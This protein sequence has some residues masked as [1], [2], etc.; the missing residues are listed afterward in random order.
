MS[1]TALTPSARLPGLLKQVFGYD[2]FR[3]LQREIMEASLARVDAVAIL[4]TGAGKSLCY[5]LPALVRDGLTVVV[6]PLIALMKDQVD[7]LHAAGVEA[8]ALNSSLDDREA[9]KRLQALDAGRI[10]LLFVAPE[11]LVLPDF[12][13]S[14]Q[15]WRVDALAVDE[16]HCISEWG[17][18]FRPEYRRLVSV[19]EVLPGVPVLALTATATPR[20]R[21]DIVTQL[22]LVDPCV[23]VA[24]FNRPNLTYRVKAKEKASAQVVEFVRA[25]STSEA[26]SM[27]DAGIVYCQSRKGTESMAAAL[28][29]KG[30]AAAP[31]HAGLDA[32][33]RARHQ[34]AF[35]RDELR[36]MCATVAFGMGINKPNVRFVIHADL[37]KNIEGY[38]QETGRA[39][40]DGL[41][42]ECLLLYSRGDVAKYIGFLA[43][44]DDLDA[45]RVARAQLDKMAAFADSARCRRVELLGYFGETWR[46]DRCDACDNCI[47]PRE[48]YDATID[49]Q[50]FL[51][52]VWRIAQKDGFGVGLQHVAD[53][54]AGADTE[55]IRRW[56]HHTLSTY[57]IGKDRPRAAWLSLG[58]Q[59]L[60]SGHLLQSAGQFPTLE[61]SELG[62]EALRSRNAILLVKS[63]VT[64]DDSDLIA[65]SKSDGKSRGKRALKAGAIECDEALFDQLRA[66]RK[67]L[68]DARGVPPYVVFSD[69]TLRH[70]A[71]SYPATRDEFLSVPGIGERKY[72]D[73]GSAF[74]DAIAQWLESHARA[75]FATDDAKSARLDA[76]A[77]AKSTSLR[78]AKEPDALNETTMQTVTLFRAG[79]S[80]DEIARVRALA[81][82]TIEGHL[83]AAIES[84]ESF[85][86]ED[87]MSAETAREIDD[88]FASDSSGGLRVIFDKLEGRVSYG[89]LR[90]SLALEQ[91][92]RNAAS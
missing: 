47:D 80:I 3:P 45:R 67:S 28:V 19:R 27:G 4:P 30:V 22:R 21:A 1:T 44:M 46:D 84:G 66:V 39:G 26:D 56:S 25:R 18:D 72:A 92:A 17:H 34:D 42:A 50:K 54:L 51:S 8:T 2:A 91:S 7:Q 88:A 63:V 40:R 75:E 23:F 41:P 11:R 52:C 85:A 62:F 9:R 15:R 24:S 53:M 55:K 83:S 70:M 32:A 5:Q 90:I 68:A 31:Y 58:R 29:A 57:G 6:S 10:K 61:I 33:M 48:S 79:H 36:V 71:R 74:G 86:R 76:P 12:L 89:L 37:P 49:A 35:L 13:R 59:L 87:F 73:F 78:K 77:R 60:Q 65:D 64:V 69:V 43:E 16:A 14:L 38:Y 20:V 82:T 81:T